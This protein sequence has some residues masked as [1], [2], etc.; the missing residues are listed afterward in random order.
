MSDRWEA[1][2]LCSN[3]VK[4]EIKYEN[5]KFRY[6]NE[7]KRLQLLDH[8]RVYS[9]KEYEIIN[10]IHISSRCSGIHKETFKVSQDGEIFFFGM[11]LKSN[12]GI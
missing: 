1:Q 9:D 3:D 10:E 5:V 2:S 4:T 11:K 7:S 6:D 12:G 8:K